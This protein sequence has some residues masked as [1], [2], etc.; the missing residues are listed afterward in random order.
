MLQVINFVTTL[1][2]IMGT[3]IGGI[4]LKP[5]KSSVFLS[6]KL[7]FEDTQANLLYQNLVS[8]DNDIF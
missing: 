6:E 3:I 5:L 1:T 8:I 2:S 4:L 7:I